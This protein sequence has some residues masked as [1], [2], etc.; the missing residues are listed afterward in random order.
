MCIR[1]RHVHAADAKAE[2]VRRAR[3]GKPLRRCG[4]RLDR[5]HDPVS[6]THLRAH[7]TVLDIVCR[8][9]L[10]KKKTNTYS[11]HNTS[12]RPKTTQLPLKQTAH[13]TQYYTTTH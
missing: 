6:Y 10:E 7:E 8:L 1:D 3:D 11:S 5:R 2:R 4:E 12:L 9:L 13:N